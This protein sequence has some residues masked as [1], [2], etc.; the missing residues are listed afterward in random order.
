MA[1]AAVVA[2]R[3]ALRAHE[4]YIREHIWVTTQ[5]IE[6]PAD[7]RHLFDTM[8]QV[9]WDR[10]LFASDYPHWDFDDPLRAFPAGLAPDRRKQILAAN[11]KAVYRLP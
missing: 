1:G 6:E 9:G 3:Q 4:E 2:P 10:L 5:P 7:P 11:A 8:E